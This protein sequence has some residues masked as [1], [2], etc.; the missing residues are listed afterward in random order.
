MMSYSI[1]SIHTILKSHKSHKIHKIQCLCLCLCLCL[2][3]CLCLCLCLCLFC[4]CFFL[5]QYCIYW[6]LLCFVGIWC[7]VNYYC[8]M[9]LQ[10]MFLD[11][12][13][14]CWRWFCVLWVIR[15]QPRECDELVISIQCFCPNNQLKFWNAYQSSWQPFWKLKS[16]NFKV[17]QTTHCLYLYQNGTPVCD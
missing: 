13:G 3:L 16:F 10:W 14:V 7:W 6:Y 15:F 5:C 11:V 9:F 1:L 4:F 8:L 2:R 17:Y 12:F